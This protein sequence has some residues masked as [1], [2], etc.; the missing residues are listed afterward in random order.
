MASDL[1]EQLSN[2]C[3][4]K[5]SVETEVRLNIWAHQL[6]GRAAVLNCS[7]DTPFQEIKLA[8]TTEIQHRQY[9]LIYFFLSWRT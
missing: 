8:I 5:L 3:K 2:W 6:N 7:P 4:V 1:K 9:Y